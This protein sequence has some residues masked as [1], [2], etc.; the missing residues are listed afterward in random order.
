MNTA[1]DGTTCDTLNH[2][3]L[4]AAFEK[5]LNELSSKSPKTVTETA[6]QHS[7]FQVYQKL[8]DG[9]EN[10]PQLT[11]DLDTILYE[12]HPGK[13]FTHQ[14]DMFTCAMQVLFCISFECPMIRLALFVYCFPCAA[15]IQGA[16]GPM[17]YCTSIQSVE[18]V[19]ISPRFTHSS[20]L[21]L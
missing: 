2:H 15:H 10:Y 12:L 8:Y 6:W 20:P 1:L 4:P 18:G 5:M 3:Y 13:I 11:M 16:Y 21:R 9:I 17:L 19:N 7:W 14:W